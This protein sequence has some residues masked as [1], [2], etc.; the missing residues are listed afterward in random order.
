MAASMSL[1]KFLLGGGIFFIGVNWLLE[2]KFREKWRLFLARPSIGVLMGLVVLHIIGTL[3]SPDAQEAWKDVRIKLPLALI[4]LVIGTSRPLEKKFFELILLVFTLAVLASCIT[5]LLVANGIVIPKKPV[6]DFRHS[7]IFVPL[8]R[9]ALMVVLCIFLLGRWMIRIRHIAVKAGCLVL[10]AGFTWFLLYMQ[11]LTGLVILVAGG[12]VL[13]VIMAFVYQR[14]KLVLF[15]LGC[16]AAGVA[17]GGFIVKK[18]YDEFYDVK[19]VNIATLDKRTSRGNAYSHD[20]AYPM[21]ENGNPV[22]MYICWPELDSAWNSRSSIVLNGGKDVNGN[23]VA[24]TLVRYLASKGWRKD[25]D[26]LGKLTDAEIVAI[27]NGATNARDPERSPIE[28]RIYQVIWEI[29]NYRHGGNPSGNSV[30]MRFELASTAWSCLAQHPWIGVGTGGQQ[31]AFEKCYAT[32]GTVLDEEWQWLHAHNQFLAI[33]AT[34]G[35]PGLVYF[36]LWLFYPASSMKRWRSYLYLAFFVVA[37]LS[38]L[39]DD[40]LETMQGVLFYAFF[41]SIFLYA[42]PRGSAIP[43]SK[44]EN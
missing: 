24:M 29:Y 19:P 30:T 43:D 33:G 10:M 11:S 1:G 41:N 6:I 44:I 13:L 12:F 16:F 18:V 31:E 23:P 9:L 3:W 5:T 8:I 35:F 42:M 36:L 7:S 39:D 27:E 28:R 22:M 40:T 38:F 21:I 4:P 15:L 17:A 34:L 32:Q 26:A 37:F 2:G 25:A 20:F 14:K